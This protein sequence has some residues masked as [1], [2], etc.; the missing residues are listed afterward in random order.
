MTGTFPSM[1]LPLGTYWCAFGWLFALG[2]AASV[3]AHEM[4]HVAALRRFGLR[5]RAPMFIPG[6]GALVRLRQ[7]SF[8]LVEDAR[9]GLAGPLWGL[10]AALAALG[11]YLVTD[12][13]GWLAIA[14]A[15]AWFNLLNL[16]PIRQLDGG[17][18]FGSLSSPQRWLAVAAVGVVY[19]LADLPP[20]LLL[21]L[22]VMF[23]EALEFNAPAKP[24][25]A[26][27]LRY[28]ALV[29]AFLAI[30]RLEVVVPGS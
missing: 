27:L 11:M 23:F 29:A 14:R 17:R 30:S 24:D 6:L 2:L 7:H 10:G 18:A 25:R 26:G 22:L 1:S 21:L 15:G 5:V 16:I 13:L 3:Y 20:P 4:G 9:I 12:G 8:N 19:V 28:V